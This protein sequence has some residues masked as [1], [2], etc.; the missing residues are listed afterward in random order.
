M[1]NGKYRG[2]LEEEEARPFFQ[3]EEA[4]IAGDE[5]KMEKHARVAP[6]RLVTDVKDH[7]LPPTL[8]L[9]CRKPV[10][11]TN[12]RQKS[13]RGTSRKNRVYVFREFLHAKFSHI[14]SSLANGEFVLDVAGGKGDLSWILCNA[15]GLNSV[16]IDPRLAKHDHLL[17]SVRYLLDHPDETAIRSVP[18]LDSHQPLATLVP[19]L[20]LVTENENG[21][22]TPRHLRIHLDDQLVKAVGCALRE[23]SNDFLTKDSSAPRSWQLYWLAASSQAGLAEP[24]GHIESGNDSS[25][26]ITDATSALRIILNARFIVGFHPDQATEACIDLA[27]ILKISF[28]VVPCCVFPSEFPHRKTKDGERVRTYEEFIEFLIGKDPSIQKA[29]LIFH[30]AT[31]ARNVVLYKKIDRSVE[32]RVYLHACP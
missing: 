14:L 26:R 9:P 13:Q 24:L 16:I 29:T 8:C 20:K 4:T 18:G 31:N 3:N 21:F 23:I 11:R 1:S 22:K 27:L 30:K 15:D 17:K 5:R 10:V 12:A 6:Y 19:R 7:G 25:G 28:V 2:S 32:E